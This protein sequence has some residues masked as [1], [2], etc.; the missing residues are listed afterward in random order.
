MEDLF[1]RWQK[2]RPE[3]NKFNEDGIIN[4]ECWESMVSAKKVLFILKETNG[5]EGSLTSFLKN[6]GNSTYYRTWNNIA[7]WAE[8]IISDTYLDKI[9]RQ[10][11]HDS[12]QKVAAINIKKQAGTSRSN[13]KTIFEAADKDQ[14]FLQEQ[15]K[16]IDA[17]I[18]ITCG[19]NVVSACL[20]DHI[21]KEPADNWIINTDTGLWY[22]YSDLIRK[23]KKTTI[24]SMPHPNRAGKDYTFK[25]KKLLQQI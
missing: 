11:L 16:K 24:I 25:L 3:Y 10:Q 1:I 13:R 21:F 18:I 7:R 15:I 8:I 20:H 19:F 14:Q 23:N 2:T 4:K 5:L 22:Y 12:L 9:S 6:G 17:E